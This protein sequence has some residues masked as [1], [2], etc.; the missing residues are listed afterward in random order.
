MLK[1]ATLFA[2]VLALPLSGIQAQERHQHEHAQSPESAQMMMHGM[3]GQ[4]MMGMGMGMMEA[5]LPPR[6]S[7]SR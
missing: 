3:M 2:A 7:Y 5:G 6:R 1:H 4:G